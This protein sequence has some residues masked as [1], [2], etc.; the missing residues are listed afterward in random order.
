LVTG[1]AWT[2]REGAKIM[3]HRLAGRVLIA[4]L[5]L[6]VAVIGGNGH[7]RPLPSVGGPAISLPTNATVNGSWSVGGGVGTCATNGAGQCAVARSKISKSNAR[8]TFTVADITHA[9]LTYASPDNHD[10]DGDG[11]GTAITVKRP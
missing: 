3:A 10:P 4:A 2:G 7:T 11:N 1:Q 9:T 8:V 5:P 6:A